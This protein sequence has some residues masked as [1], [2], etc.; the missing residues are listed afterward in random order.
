MEIKNSNIK[1]VINQIKNKKD[2]FKEILDNKKGILKGQIKEIKGNEVKILTKEGEVIKARLD[3]TNEMKLGDYKAFEVYVEKGILKMRELKGISGENR[4]IQI[5]N[6]LKDLGLPETKENIQMCKN[7]LE[8]KLPVNKKTLMDLNR[9]IKI[10][11]NIDNQKTGNEFK[12]IENKAKQGIFVLKNEVPINSKNIELLNKLIMK[13]TNM[14]K[15]IDDL[16][17]EVRKIEDKVVKEKLE[18]ILSNKVTSEKDL[19]T[20][21]SLEI[22]KDGLA[23]I[24]NKW[25][26]T[27]KKLLVEKL[28]KGENSDKGEVLKKVVVEKTDIT[29]DKKTKEQKEKMDIKVLGEE[30]NIETKDGKGE[31]KE[32]ITVYKKKG[33][34]TLKKMIDYLNKKPF[35]NLELKNI[36]KN[37]MTDIEKKELVK[38]INNQLNNKMNIDIK[39]FSKGLVK[40][41]MEENSDKLE[42]IIKLLENAEEE[43]E[44]S[45]LKKATEI[46]EKQEIA[47]LIKES[48][49]MEIP[50]SI[51]N[52]KVNTELL[53]FSNKNNKNK[54]SKKN[55]TALVSLNTKNLGLVETY[56]EKEDKEIKLQFRLEKEGVEKIIK[57]KINIINNSLENRGYIVK[58]VQYK[59]IEES[60]GILDI[61]EKEIRL[62]NLGE[63]YSIEI[64][65]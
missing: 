18:N 59:K 5:K 60:F 25:S 36:I 7:L 46:R 8:N 41:Y 47:K 39:L 16:E 48:T 63:D 55:I 58:S 44:K 3:S 9:I 51:G 35:S 12:E 10:L 64:K 24:E 14:T 61:E 11:D 4:E 31:N 56:I 21:K 37:H 50:M 62:N 57:S 52:K 43:V 30:K 2:K 32:N 29:I 34:E 6:V 13:E 42:K 38:V 27:N 20:N 17:N 40:E 49:Y 19:L 65:I 22:I 26:D 15:E 28:T 33:N 23:K 1:P 45:I 53:V 54:K